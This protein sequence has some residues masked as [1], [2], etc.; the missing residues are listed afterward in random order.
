[1]SILCP[2]CV[3]DNPDATQICVYCGSFIAATGSST[4]FLHLPTGSTLKQGQYQIEDLLGEGGFGI[5]YK[6]TY[7]ANG[8]PVAIKELWPEK[9]SRQSNK[10]MWPN[11]ITPQQKFQQLSKFKLEASHQQKCSHP[12]IAQVYDWFDENDTCY[13]VMQFISGKPLSKIFKEE[14]IL[15]ENRVTRY[16]IQ[17]TE[18]LKIVHQNQFLHRDIKP[19]NIIRSSSTYR[20]WGC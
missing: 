12:N 18:A 14:G 17:I 8:A 9:G 11:S 4:S 7:L 16:F 13:I 3:N 19:D 2:N 6:G 5:T 15:Q 20:F 1:M 10:V